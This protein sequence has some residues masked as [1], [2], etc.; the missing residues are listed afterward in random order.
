MTSGPSRHTCST[1]GIRKRIT[2]FGGPAAP[3]C[4]ACG[5]SFSWGV[6]TTSRL[7]LENSRSS[8][9]ASTRRSD[10]AEANGAAV[11]LSTSHRPMVQNKRYVLSTANAQPETSCVYI[12]DPRSESSPKSRIT[13]IV[14]TSSRGPATAVRVVGG[15]SDTVTAGPRHDSLHHENLTT[16]SLAKAL[17]GS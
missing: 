3:F 8:S 7:R 6:R 15:S 2:A 5:G 1:T 12:P 4:M 16:D 13:T 14:A 10:K 11:S 9:A 17:G